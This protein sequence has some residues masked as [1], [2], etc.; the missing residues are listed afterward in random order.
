MKK[1]LKGSQKQTKILI[2]RG[3]RKK[4]TVDFSS[5]KLCKQEEST[6]KSLSC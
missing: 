3:K 6:V 4:I 5:E 1:N 2:Y